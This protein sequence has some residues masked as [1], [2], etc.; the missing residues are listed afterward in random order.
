MAK[1]EDNKRAYLLHL[2]VK[3][4]VCMKICRYMDFD[5][6][7]QVLNGQF[8]VAVKR[9]FKDK[10]DAGV[11]V[12]QRYLFPIVP[13]SE[14]GRAI[15]TEVERLDDLWDKVGQSDECLT[16]C[17]TMAV[18]DSLMWK[19]YT[20]GNCGVC[21]VSTIYNVVASFNSLN[22]HTAYCSRM[23]YDGFSYN[24]TS[25][26]YM[27]TK[28]K[29]YASEQEVRFYFLNDDTD[30]PNKDAGNQHKKPEWFTVSPDVMIDRVILSPYMRGNSFNLLKQL[31]TKAYPFLEKRIIR[32]GLDEKQ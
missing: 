23:F 21:M 27:F 10:Y 30:C 28:A 9:D 2:N 15:P 3:H 19:A 17:W 12:P 8:Y 1:T 32:S 4:D 6:F 11:K 7:L 25:A 5:N 29:G 20:S 31:L 18:D 13:A 14:P 16:S 26:D 22:G 24:D